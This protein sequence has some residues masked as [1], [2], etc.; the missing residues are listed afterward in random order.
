[1]GLIR[2]D[3]EP[4]LAAAKFADYTPELGVCQWF[5]FEDP[6]LDS[7]VEWLKKLG[8]TRLRTGLSW[9]DSHREN[10]DRWFDQQM[11]ALDDFDVTLTFCFTPESRG[12]RPHHTS[13]PHSPEEFAEFCA[14]MVR[15][16][17]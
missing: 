6:R 11:K 10:A 13:P 7:G 1:M 2:A 12:K 5:H 4:K 8:V 3:G 17:A 15:R 16:Y 9:A 14:R